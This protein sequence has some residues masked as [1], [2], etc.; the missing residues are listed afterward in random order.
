MIHCIESKTALFPLRACIV[1]T[2]IYC[3]ALWDISS[4]SNTHMVFRNDL[5]LHCVAKRLCIKSFNSY[6]KAL[7]NTSDWSLRTTK[8]P[9]LDPWTRPLI[10]T[11]IIQLLDIVNTGKLFKE[12]KINH[13]NVWRAYVIYVIFHLNIS[14]WPTAQNVQYFQQLNCTA[15]VGGVTMTSWWQWLVKRAAVLGIITTLVQAQMLSYLKKLCP[16]FRQAFLGGVY[17]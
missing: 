14:F 8:V 1:Q 16:L 17:V 10:F 12:N 9:L 6:I 4:V 3:S 11:I 13:L 15:P 7:W 5:M 2:L